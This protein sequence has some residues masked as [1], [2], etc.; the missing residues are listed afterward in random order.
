M[1]NYKV[2]ILGDTVNHDTTICLW[3]GGALSS[4]PSG[5]YTFY[6]TNTTSDHKQVYSAY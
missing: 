4:Q 5:R 1:K 3:R 6:T 2:Y